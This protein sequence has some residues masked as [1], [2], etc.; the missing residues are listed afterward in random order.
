MW[1]LAQARKFAS[2]LEAALEPRGWHVAL[3][4]SVLHKGKSSK[5]LD[6]IVYP[7]S[8]ATSRY[9]EIANGLKAVGCSLKF[10]AEKVRGFWRQT[11]SQDR[12]HVEVWYFVDGSKIK[13]IDVFVMDRELVS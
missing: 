13:R 3:A 10:S 1:T 4:G 9:L 12:K 2:S 8:T 5:D 7:R 11:S 6:L